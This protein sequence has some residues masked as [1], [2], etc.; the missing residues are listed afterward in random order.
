[1]EFNKA[2]YNYLTSYSGLSSLVSNRIYPDE[3]PQE[4][5]YPAI[6]YTLTD[7]D[8]VETFQTPESNLISP[9]YEF[10]CHAS[11]RA[12][13]EAVAKQLRLAFKNYSGVMGG[14]GG[15]TV[16]AVRKLGRDS[17]TAYDSSGK[18]IA[19]ISVMDFQICY[20]E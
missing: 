17:D 2:L 12:G 20:Q 5:T 9:T 10:E 3:L 7:E 4:P 14:D 1:M 13:A 15:I 8:E 18:V 19:R 16:E 6:V 11:T